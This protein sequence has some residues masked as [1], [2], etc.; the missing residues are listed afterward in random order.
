MGDSS[1]KRGEADGDDGRRRRDSDGDTGNRDTA[2]IPRADKNED[3]SRVAQRETG[4]GGTRR[5]IT[6][7]FQHQNGS[8]GGEYSGPSG[9]AGF[10]A[11]GGVNGNFDAGDTIL[12]HGETQSAHHAGPRNDASERA[13]AGDHKL[14]S[15]STLGVAYTSD[16][17]MRS[18]ATAV[19]SEGVAVA[20]YGDGVGGVTRGDTHG[21]QG[22]PAYVANNNLTESAQHAGAGEMRYGE[23]DNTDAVPWE[24]DGAN[25]G[26]API[27]HGG[28]PTAGGYDD[29]AGGGAHQGDVG[30]NQRNTALVSPERECDGGGEHNDR[31]DSDH[32]PTA[33]AGVVEQGSKT[34]RATD[35]ATGVLD[36]SIGAGAPSQTRRPKFDSGQN[37][38]TSLEIYP[39]DTKY[40]GP[41][42]VVSISDGES[43]PVQSEDGEGTKNGGADGVPVGTSVDNGDPGGRRKVSFDVGG[44]DSSSPPARPSSSLPPQ[45]SMGEVAVVR[46]ETDLI[47]F[48]RA[49]CFLFRAG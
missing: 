46:R 39:G 36:A 22:S 41:S 7:E 32:A 19:P 6:V 31:R 28:R 2:G 3:S 4:D 9:N 17:S 48:S 43:R 23:H 35:D 34:N 8:D 37:S 16:T 15:R 40:G 38:D 47:F 18:T 42:A 27:D 21:V 33:P 44:L 14:S 13:A 10:G 20:E 29:T 1:R 49:W 26:T 12:T 25:N 30:R 5:S 24:R 11:K 45:V